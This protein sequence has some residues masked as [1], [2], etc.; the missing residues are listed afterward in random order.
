MIRFSITDLLSEQECHDFLLKILHPEGLRCKNG[1]PLANG[2]QPHMSDRA[3][4]VDY[5]CRTCGAV[6]NLFTGKV[7]AGTHYS[8]RKIVLILRGFAQ[9]IPT[10]QIA[11]ELEC[12]YG[13]LLNYRHEMQSAALLHQDVSPL[14]DALTEADEGNFSISPGNRQGYA[15]A[16]SIRKGRAW[17][18][19]G[20]G[21]AFLDGNMVICR[22]FLC[23]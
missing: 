17:W 1:H 4:V 14:L 18:E 21:R 5:R 7:W 22:M 9:G 3:P 16:V 15:S 19:P 8:C 12:D 20:Y 23:R 2:Q 6:F 10:L 11:D 13:T